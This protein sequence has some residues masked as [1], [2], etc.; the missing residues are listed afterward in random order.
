MKTLHTMCVICPLLIGASCVEQTSAMCRIVDVNSAGKIAFPSKLLLE[1]APGSGGIGSTANYVLLSP[2]LFQREGVGE[3]SKV[4][5]MADLE[6]NAS[7]CQA[8]IKTTDHMVICSAVVP[9]SSLQ[10]IV[11]Y[12]GAPSLAKY[13]VHVLSIAEDVSS[14]LI[15]CERNNPRKA[16]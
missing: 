2:A 4:L 11:S 5:V 10:V 14:Q 3:I 12:R 16:G 1:V 9:R 15:S 6:H 7:G 8:D 13:Q